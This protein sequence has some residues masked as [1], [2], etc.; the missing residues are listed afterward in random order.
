MEV[1]KELE[2]RADPDN[3]DAQY[4]WARRN[5]GTACA[6]ATCALEEIALVLAQVPTV[7]DPDKD[8]GVEEADPYVLAVA[9]RLKDGGV[10]GRVITEE[11]HDTPA[12]MSINTAAGVLGLPSVPLRAFLTFER[13][14]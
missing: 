7:L 9:L 6:E 2:R 14:P 5:S 1:L 8:S 11:R 10:D 12:K 4:E 13:I 3:P